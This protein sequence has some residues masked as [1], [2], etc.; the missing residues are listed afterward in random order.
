M[1][2]WR[3]R[4]RRAPRERGNASMRGIEGIKDAATG[5]RMKRAEAFYREEEEEDGRETRR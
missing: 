2:P 3:R 1:K 5:A 4:W